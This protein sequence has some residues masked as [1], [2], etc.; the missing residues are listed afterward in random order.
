MWADLGH[1]PAAGLYSV[2]IALVV[3]IISVTGTIVIWLSVRN[4]QIPEGEIRNRILGI[5]VRWVRQQQESDQQTIH[6]HGVLTKKGQK[7][8]R[9]RAVALRL[10]VNV[11]VSALPGLY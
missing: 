4:S 1:V 9:L 8:Y 3:P 6:R 11:C 5:K 2:V 7:G 10:I